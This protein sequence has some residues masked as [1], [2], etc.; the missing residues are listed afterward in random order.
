MEEEGSTHDQALQQCV[1]TRQQ[2]QQQR[3]GRRGRRQG[4]G[5]WLGHGKGRL[6]GLMTKALC[7]GVCLCGRVI[8]LLEHER[9][10]QERK[11]ERRVKVEVE[12]EAQLQTTQ[13]KAKPVRG[14]A[15]T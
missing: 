2:Q 14:R 13:F 15:E 9:A 12:N 8:G 1:P 10:M 3:K 5:G 4:R 6:P 7:S 11:S